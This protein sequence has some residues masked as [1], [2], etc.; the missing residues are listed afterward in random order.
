M[1]LS[2]FAIIIT[3]QWTLSFMR[4][5]DSSPALYYKW[6]IITMRLSCTI[7]EIWH[8]KDNGVTTLTFGVTWHHWSRDHSTTVVDFLWVVHCDHASIWHRYGDMALQMLNA[9]TL[10]RIEKKKKGKRK[11]K[12]EGKERESGRGKG[13][14]REGEREGKL[15]GRRKKRETGR[16]RGK[17]E[18][19]NE[20]EGKGE[21][22]LKVEG[23]GEGEREREGEDEKKR[24]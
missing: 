17:G 22:E 11:R 24:A 15:K 21:G 3:E 7:M 18:R 23:E 19:E 4:P 12:G 1:L 6:S 10:T 9:R 20:R 2:S 13:R 8:L 5:F 16:G 14:E